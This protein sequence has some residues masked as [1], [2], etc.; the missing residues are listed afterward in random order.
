MIHHLV[1][2]VL[3][4]IGVVLLLYYN[5]KI[6]ICKTPSTGTMY[7][8]GCLVRTYVFFVLRHCQISALALSAMPIVIGMNVWSC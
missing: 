8:F 6:P 5:D 4:L 1:V 7:R 2:G 3:V